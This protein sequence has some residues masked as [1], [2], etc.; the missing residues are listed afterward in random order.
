M[1]TFELRN[2]KTGRLFTDLQK[3]VILELPKVPK[4][5]DGHPIWPQ[6]QFLK[7]KAEEDM[8]LLAEKHPEVKPLVAEYKHFTLLEKFR[9]R[10]RQREKDRRDAWAMREYIKDEGRAE[11]EKVIAEKDREITEQARVNAEL[12]QEIAE[13]KRLL[14]YQKD[15]P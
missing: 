7:C 3:Y 13:L 10:A 12:A 6:L 15:H 8:T 5:D 1:N 4:D 11:M 14:Q 2:N 9:L